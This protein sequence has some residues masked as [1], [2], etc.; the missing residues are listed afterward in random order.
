M[1]KGTK[2][3]YSGIYFINSLN[4]CPREHGNL[5]TPLKDTEYV[6]TVKET[7]QRVKQQYTPNT[8]PPE[9]CN[10]TNITL[11]VYKQTLIKKNWTGS[12][13]IEMMI[14]VLI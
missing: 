2:C 11:L 8:Q 9:E 10:N 12:L 14:Y 7:K 3:Y 5:G 4:N 6:R 13:E 1:S